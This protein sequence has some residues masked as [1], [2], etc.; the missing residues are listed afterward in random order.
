M[1]VLSGEELLERQHLSAHR[2]A[3][4][5]AI[6]QLAYQPARNFTLLLVVIEHHRSV[7]SAHVLVALTIQVCRIVQ[8]EVDVQDLLG[9]YHVRLVFELNYLGVICRTR[10]DL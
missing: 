7:L 10:F 3:V 6:I 8:E 2:R 5:L 1:I 9:A 4:R